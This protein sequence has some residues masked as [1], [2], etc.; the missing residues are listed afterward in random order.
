MEYWA[1]RQPEL[2][3]RRIDGD[4]EYSVIGKIKLI[5]QGRWEKQ[6]RKR[7]GC[8]LSVKVEANDN[9]HK[10]GRHHVNWPVGITWK[11]VTAAVF[12]NAEANAIYVA[13]GRGT[14]KLGQADALDKKPVITEVFILY[15]SGD[16]GFGNGFSQVQEELWQLM[17]FIITNTSD[18]M[19]YTPSTNPPPRFISR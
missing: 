12:L 11:Q 13:S 15:Q 9:L 16:P 17:L 1:H 19:K 3:N 2:R 18:K 8:R 7:Y 10:T 14:V 4:E 6:D 5:K